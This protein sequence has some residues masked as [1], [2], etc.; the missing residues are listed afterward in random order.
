M[1]IRSVL[2]DFFEPTQHCIAKVGPCMLILLEQE[3]NPDTEELSKEMYMLHV[4]FVRL[5]VFID[6]RQVDNFYDGPFYSHSKF[7]PFFVGACQQ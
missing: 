7:R 5:F 1:Y 4:L 2:I 3:L 6:G